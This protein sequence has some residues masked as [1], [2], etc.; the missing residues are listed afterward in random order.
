M[1]ANPNALGVSQAIALR[2]TNRGRTTKFT[3]ERVQQITNLVERGKRRDEIAEIIGVTVGTLQ[4]TCSKLGVSLRP[5]AFNN[6]IGLLRR[7]RPRSRKAPP[8]LQPSSP[9]ES[10]KPA[11][12]IQSDSHGNLI[13]EAQAGTLH[14]EAR[15]SMASDPASPTFAVR[16]E[17]KG[18]ERLSALPL[19][20]AM[21]GQLALEAEF[22]G[23][24]MGELVSA[25]ILTITRE[26]LFQLVLKHD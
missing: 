18:K 9:R 26:D 15:R 8:T 16:I 19:D 13:K 22:R 1:N 6:G 12:G 14:Q 20:Q 5:P 3:P 24:R 23:M 4:V 25:L 10:T 2:P 11:N 7:R 17:Y 21:I